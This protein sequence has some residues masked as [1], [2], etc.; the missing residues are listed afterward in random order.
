MSDSSIK[1]LHEV[2]KQAKDGW[3][4]CLQHVL[5]PY[6]ECD[7]KEGYGFIWRTEDGKCSQPEGKQGFLLFQSP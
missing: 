5:Y 6:P 7:D 4:L 1:V 2:K 3:Y